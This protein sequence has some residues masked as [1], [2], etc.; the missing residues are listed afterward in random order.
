M[1]VVKLILDNGADVDLRGI[2]GAT[3]LIVASTFGHTDIV[4]LLLD[5]GASINERGGPGGAAALY[6]AAKEGHLNAVEILLQQGATVDIRNTEAR[7]P[8]HE[9]VLGGYAE[10]TRLL[11]EMGEERRRSLA[12]R[13]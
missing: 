7:T 1:E 3:A 10:I 8:L 9:A 11:L 2:D 12:L 6:G 4:K 13:V 5:N